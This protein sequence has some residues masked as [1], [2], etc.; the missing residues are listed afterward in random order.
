MKDKE[1]R[2]IDELLAPSNLRMYREILS[3]PLGEEMDQYIDGSF[4]LLMMQMQESKKQDG[5]N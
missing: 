4:I 3:E 5:G 2:I 1:Q